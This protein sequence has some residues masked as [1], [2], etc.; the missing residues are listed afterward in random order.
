MIKY[1]DIV[2]GILSIAYYLYLKI[3]YGGMSFSILFV[4]IG[5]TLIIYHF[6]K[7]KINRNNIL[8][9]ITKLITIACTVIFIT[10]ESLIIFYPKNNTKGACDYLIVLGAAVNNNSPGIT[11]KKRLDTAINYISNSSDDC[12]II[13]TGGK[14]SN[15]YISEAEVM[16]NYLIDNQVDENKI[17]MED[18][19]NNTYENF[20]FSKEIIEK[21]SNKN[22]DKLKIKVITTDFHSFRSS[23]I[24][25]REGY[26]DITFY[27]SKSLKQF[28]PVYYTR[29]FFATLKTVIFN[30]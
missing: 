1:L 29:E 6:I 17:I 15:K 4:G 5:L 23:I 12:K 9:K 20:K 26:N 27:T 25:S 11:L 16:K 3:V 24:A 28:V 21:Q 13:V 22:V 8:Y 30:Y 7:N 10:V 2:I 18:K 19:A 14:V